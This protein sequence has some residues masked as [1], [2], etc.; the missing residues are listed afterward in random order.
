MKQERDR[1]REGRCGMGMCLN[2]ENE[3]FLKA[4]RSEIYVD[5]N[6]VYIPNSEVQKEFINSGRKFRQEFFFSPIVQF[7]N[8]C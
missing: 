2:L 3:M 5:K 7:G 6:E 8:M 1:L 4:V